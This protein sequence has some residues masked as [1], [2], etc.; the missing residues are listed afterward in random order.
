METK[1][2]PLSTAGMVLTAVMAAVICILAP[3]SIPLPGGLVP[4]SL[5]T[6]AVYLSANLLGWK[7]GTLS[8][9][10]YL[11]LGL[12]GLPVFSA[13]S[14]GAG[15][16]LGPTGGYLI[17]YIPLALISGSFFE[18]FSGTGLFDRIMGVAGAILA[19]AVLYVIGTLWLMKAAG[20][21]LPA[22][23]ATGM[24]PFIPG[25]LVKIIVVVLIGPEIRKRLLAAGIQ[26]PF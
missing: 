10:L 25:D 22:A 2:K 4:I 26:L 14:S 16:L 3:I 7:P 18:R 6:F 24:L 19:T 13:Y 1:A 11:L 23:I 12:V 20:L 17:G 9:L 8:T 15:I 21:G 5:A